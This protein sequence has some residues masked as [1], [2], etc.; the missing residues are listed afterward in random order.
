MVAPINSRRIP[1]PLAIVGL[2]GIYFVVG[3]FCLKLAS[4]NASASPV[5]PPAGIALAALLISGY[6]IWPGIFIGAFL[7]NAL[8]AGNVATSLGIAGG[9]TLEA[10]C[11]AW[12]INYFCGGTRAFER[13]RDVFKFAFAVVVSAL[14]SPTIGV[15]SLALGKFADWNNYGAVWFTWWS[16]DTTG[17]LIVAPL[18]VLWSR[19]SGLRW[20]RREAI[21]VTSLLI[22]VVLVGEAVFG[23][24]FPISAKNYP[25]SFV[26]APIL[27]WTAFRFSQRETATGIFI[28]SVIAIWGTLRHRGP[29][30]METDNQSLL[31]LQASTAVLFITAMALAAAMAERRRAEE[32]LE[33]QKETI[34]AA[35]KTKDYFLAMLSH[36]LRTP[37]TPVLAGLDALEAEASRSKDSRAALAMIRR[38]VELESQLIDDLL[39]LTRITRDKLQLT[40]SP[41]DAHEAISNVVEICRAELTARGIQ[42]HMNLRAQMHHIAADPAKL[43][44]IIW[45]LLKNAIK[46]TGEKG[47]IAVSTTNSSPGWLEIT[48]QDN[49]IGIEPDLLARIFDPFE[50]GAQSFHKRAGGLGLG[51][52]ISKSLTQAHGGTLVA[53]SDGRNKGARFVVSMRTIA[54]TSAEEID[55]H[56]T[57]PSVRR[58]LRILLV[59]DHQDTCTALEKLLVR[60]GHL[61]AAT[62]S[63]R[64]AMEAAVK[65]QFDLL[66]SDIALPDGSGTDLMMQVRAIRAIPGIAMSGFGMQADIDRSLQAGFVDHLVKP[67]KP[68]QLEALID[69]IMQD[70]TA[71]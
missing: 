23:G 69:R 44:Q 20:T 47:E 43:Q 63:M 28:L 19:A 57:V 22:L 60:R 65:N 46:F 58:G 2:A 36:E 61:V 10:L 3:Y 68:E 32:A 45:N 49:G 12:F 40:L 70:A 13:A 26:L 9:N 59:D 14:I 27:V 25:M 66:L 5:W 48:V 53:R 35:N 29:F 21:E 50:Q 18:I 55:N 34:E 39:D 31:I 17:D 24:W 37:L 71:S 33:S 41:I 16:G 7:V 54:P 64:A 67:V 30:I 62:H 51:L 4:L 8:T 6:R 15:T 56:A 1:A 42:L 11:G 38:N 52:A